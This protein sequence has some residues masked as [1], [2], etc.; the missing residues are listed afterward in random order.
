MERNCLSGLPATMTSRIGNRFTQIPRR[1]ATVPRL[2][3]TTRAVGIR[4]EIEI[5]R[6]DCGN[7]ESRVTL[8]SAFAIGSHLPTTE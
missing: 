2:G 3:A 5:D 6:R 8:C 1:S 4:T 7:S